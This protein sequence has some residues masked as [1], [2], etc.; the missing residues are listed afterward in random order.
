MIQIDM[1]MPERCR[2]CRFFVDCDMCEG[3][4]SRC[5][6]LDD[7]F[8][9]EFGGSIIPEIRPKWCPLIPVGGKLNAFEEEMIKKASDYWREEMRK[10][11]FKI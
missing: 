2:D 9:E 1:E 3:K 10:K 7:Y 11:G 5:T 6:A 8:D 4:T